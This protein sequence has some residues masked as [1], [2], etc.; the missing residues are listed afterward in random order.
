MMAIL[1]KMAIFFPCRSSPM[2]DDIDIATDLYLNEISSAIN[3][4]RQ[5]AGV[6]TEGSKTCG[7]CGESIPEA[8]K[9]LGFKL[10]VPCAE[11]TERRRRLFADD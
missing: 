3:K 1:S 7:E 8:R 5:N 2:A 6:A 4:M 11:D 10:C 9:K